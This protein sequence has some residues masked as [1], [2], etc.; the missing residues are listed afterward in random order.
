MKVFLIAVLALALAGCS[1]TKTLVKGVDNPVTL[2]DLYRVEQAAVILASGL[3][4]YRTLCLAKKI[5]QK[6]R[7]V[8]VQAQSFTR[9]AGRYL[10]TLRTYFKNNDRL[11]AINAYNV[12]VQLLS[13]AQAVAKTNGV[14]L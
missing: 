12:L 8:I 1:T 5:D 9:P 7:D 6:C 3:N 4:A 14:A 11:N 10:V 13:D 2:E